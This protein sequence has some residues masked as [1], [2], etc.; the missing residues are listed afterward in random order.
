MK[1]GDLVRCIRQLPG[2]PTRRALALIVGFDKDDDPIISYVAGD[3]TPHSV[4]RFNIQ[5]LSSGQN[6]SED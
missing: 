4:Y 3:H 1:V 5:L 2:A 6:V